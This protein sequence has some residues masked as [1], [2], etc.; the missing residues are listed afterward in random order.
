MYVRSCK[1]EPYE[2]T[3]DAALIEYATPG[4]IFRNNFTWKFISFEK[5]V[6]LLLYLRIKNTCS[7]LVVSGLR[8]EIKIWY[9]K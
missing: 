6:L 3:L 8:Y 2:V 1:A 4:G 9:R 7:S 5:R